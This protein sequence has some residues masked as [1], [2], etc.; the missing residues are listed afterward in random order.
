[1]EEA[2]KEEEETKEE[3]KEEVKEEETEEAKEETKEEAE[4]SEEEP[5]PVAELTAEDKEQV[6]RTKTVPDLTQL[7]L[8][9]SY[10]QFTIPEKSEGF[11]EVKFVWDKEAECKNSLKSW[12]KEQKMTCR[13]DELKPGDWFKSKSLEWTK[14]IKE[15]QT[16]A[17]TAAVEAAKAKKDKLLAKAKE[18]KE[19]EDAE[20]EEEEETA[21]DVS[22]VAD[23]T[24]ADGKGEGMLL[25][26][27][28]THEDW[29]MMQ[30]RSDLYLLIKAFLKDTED[31]ERTGIPEAH[32]DFYYKKYFKRELAAKNFGL[33]EQKEVFA[34]AKDCVKL[35]DA[36]LY[37][38]SLDEETETLDVFVKFAEELRR[39]RQR[40]IDAGDETARVK[41]LSSCMVATVAPVAQPRPVA[42]APGGA[43][44]AG[45][46][47]KGG[48][49]G[50]WPMGARPSG[51]IR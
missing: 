6:Y 33:K 5:E 44:G 35:T 36:G 32:I 23:V 50:A 16:K 30:V 7:A 47:G 22:A 11:Q 40:R 34:L 20:E 51:I 41:F 12:V 27:D 39:E 38:V 10:A 42:G 13:L 4:E 3:P 37:E 43:A 1:M 9:K 19:G 31:D 24:D 14:T 18:K 21:V 15:W 28:F 17:K 48:K 46:W 25:F 26:K 45:A 2:K 8:S 49:G 29:A